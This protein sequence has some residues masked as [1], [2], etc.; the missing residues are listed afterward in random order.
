MH[1]AT[2][3]AMCYAMHRAMHR[4]LHHAMCHAM[5][6]YVAP[7]R[8][9]EL[10]ALLAGKEVA[11]LGD[12]GCTAFSTAADD[13]LRGGSGRGGSVHGSR[14]EEASPLGA[15]GSYTTHVWISSAAGVPARLDAFCTLGSDAACRVSLLVASAATAEGP[16]WVKS[17]LSAMHA[18]A[19]GLSVAS[20]TSLGGTSLDGTS[21]GG[22]SLGAG[23]GTEG[24]EAVGEEGARREVLVALLHA[25]KCGAG[26]APKGDALQQR[27]QGLF[28]RLHVRLV[29]VIEGGPRAAAVAQLHGP[30]EAASRAVLDAAPLEPCACHPMR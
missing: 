4:T 2:R 3:R 11:E 25:D 16:A 6:R 19:G 13:Q 27:W 20:G 18:E 29:A 23:V 9:T 12:A 5:H 21:L 10:A 22:T 24:A 15:G 17:A 14:S 1:R 8:H 7:C 30:L 28:P 26:G